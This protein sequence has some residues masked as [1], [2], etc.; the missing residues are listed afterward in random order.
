MQLQIYSRR[1]AAEALRV[2]L[3]TLD[4]LLAQGKLRGRRIGRRVLVP[5]SELEK[6]LRRD[7][8]IDP[9]QNNGQ[10]RV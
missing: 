8:E 7:T 2:S 4:T 5:Q 3:R 1:E 10:R 9:A 6:L